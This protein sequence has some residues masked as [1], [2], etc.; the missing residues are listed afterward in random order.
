MCGGTYIHIRV[1]PPYFQQ[2]TY[3]H[4]RIYTVVNIILFHSLSLYTTFGVI[5]LT[6][7][8]TKVTERFDFYSITLLCSMFTLKRDSCM[9]LNFAIFLF[10]HSR[11]YTYILVCMRCVCVCGTLCALHCILVFVFVHKLV[12]IRLC[13]A[14]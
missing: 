3:I 5:Q 9:R 7:R 2:H 12:Y 14:T 10:T 4:G 1:C 13:N 8:F 11:A 6:M